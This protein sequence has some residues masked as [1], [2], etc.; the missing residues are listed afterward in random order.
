MSD[1]QKSREEL[2]AGYFDDTLSP[3]EK[4]YVEEWSK[5]NQSIFNDYQKTWH[6]FLL[7]EQ[8]KRFDANVALSRFNQSC[9]YN[10]NRPDNIYFIRRIA[11]ILIIPILLGSLYFSF[12]Y[13]HNK[14]TALIQPWQTITTPLGT[15]TSFTL[16]DGTKVWLNSGSKLSFPSHFS[17]NI[18]EVKP[19]GE[20]Y[21]DVAPKKTKPFIVNCGKIN[22]KVLGTKFNVLYSPTDRLTKIALAHGKIELFTGDK[23]SPF[24]L[25]QLKPGEL[26]TYNQEANNLAIKTDNIEKHIGWINGRLFFE[27]DPMPVVVDKLERYFNIKLEYKESDWDDFLLNANFKEESLIQIM[28]LMKVS[29]PLKYDIL[30]REIQTDGS[31]DKMQI[32]IYK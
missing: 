3:K 12:L 24:P 13:F 5:S 23:N 1:Q 21:F 6:F 14:Q 27:D 31:Y 22:V 11:A 7:K 10:N 17:T 29:V 4:A 20:V 26:A 32:K 8:M 30:P 18:R 25:L 2:I 15:R 16:E 28:E 9:F 19:Y